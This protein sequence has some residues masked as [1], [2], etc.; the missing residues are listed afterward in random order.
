V[1]DT[2]AGSEKGRIRITAIK[3]MGLKRGTSGQSLETDA[4]IFTQSL[5]KIETDAGIYG[6]GEAGAVASSV[7]AHMLDYAPMLIGQDPLEIEKHYQ[8]MTSKMHAAMAH[9]PTISGLDIALWDIAGKVLQRPVSSL[10]TGRFRNEATL[11]CHGIGPKDWLDKAAWHDWAR[12]HRETFPG[13]Q[14]VKIGFEPLMGTYLPPNRWGIAQPSTTL[15]Q[16]ELRIVGKGFENCREAL[17]PDLDFIVHCHNEWDLPTSIGLTEVLAPSSPLWLED[18]L[19]VTYSDT[20]K[21]LKQAARMRIATGEKLELPREFYPFLANGA[22]DV[23]HPDL[24]Y[25]GGF[26]GCRKIA[27]LAEMFY[28]PVILHCVGSVVHLVANAHFGASVRNFIMSE[29]VLRPGSI[30]YDMSEE[31]I[32]VV[33]GK[34][35]VPTGPG[36]GITLRQD[37]LRANLAEGEIYWG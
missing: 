29:T 19:P 31:G 6:I 9:I 18:P 25:A 10:L 32:K 4:G 21:F 22:V 12:Q 27:D 11:Y 30:I 20:W 16:N 36:L 13:W 24:V 28:V 7:R 33:D 35:I 2:L 5:I 37:I 3:V 8:N 17:G 14:T 34:L 23:I 15:S 26:T 1:L